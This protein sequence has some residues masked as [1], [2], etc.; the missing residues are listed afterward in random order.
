V[1]ELFSG[2]GVILPLTQ[3]V[4]VSV[5]TLLPA[6]ILILSLVTVP[7]IPVK[8]S[9]LSSSLEVRTDILCECWYPNSLSE[10]DT[11]LSA[12]DL[13]YSLAQDMRSRRITGGAISLAL[14]GVMF[15]ASA[16]SSGDDF[17]AQFTRTFGLV[18][19]GIF[20]GAGIGLLAIPTSAEVQADQ[21]TGISNPDDRERSA[22]AGLVTLAEKARNQRVLGGIVSCGSGLALL[23]MSTEAEYSDPTVGLLLIGEG[24]YFLTSPSPEER[25][26]NKYEEAR[27]GQ[28]L[29]CQINPDLI[30]ADGGRRFGIALRVAFNR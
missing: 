8:A 22:Y 2:A 12:Q 26:L 7:G 10:I 25:I 23:V 19:G 1:Q 15:I 14:G 11:I 24:I 17:D 9:S 29:L 6:S 5:R 30:I 13:L 16:G 27:S 28:P 20:A 4:V 21:V 18:S 3:E